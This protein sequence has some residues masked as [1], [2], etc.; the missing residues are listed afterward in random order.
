[1]LRTYHMFW[2]ELHG[3]SSQPAEQRHFWG[4]R[5]TRSESNHLKRARSL[6]HSD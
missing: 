4:V 1:M 2:D 3:V 6:N 5:H